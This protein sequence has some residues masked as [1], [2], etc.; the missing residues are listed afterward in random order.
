[1]TI[2]KGKNGGIYQQIFVVCERYPAVIGVS[3]ARL[4]VKP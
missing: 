3:D 2:V 1:M 4:G